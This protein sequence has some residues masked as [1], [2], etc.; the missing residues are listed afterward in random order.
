MA[1]CVNGRGVVVGSLGYL[2][3]VLAALLHNL[4]TILVIINSSRLFGYVPASAKPEAPNSF[5]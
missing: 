2:N 4:S 1:I 5:L 3:P